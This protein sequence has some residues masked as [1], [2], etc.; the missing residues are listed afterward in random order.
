MRAALAA[1]ILLTPIAASAQQKAA[2]A[3]GPDL[4]A[5][6]AWITR[7][8]TEW[9]IPGVAVGIVKDGKVV[10]SKG[11]GYRN[12]EEK[13]P[14]TEKTI[15]A[16]GSNTKSF[17]V[18]L[19][20]KLVDQGKLDWE[21]PVRNYLPDFRLYDA[22]ATAEMTPRDLVSHSSG[23]PR[24]DLL[25]YGRSWGRKE[26]YQRLQYLEPTTS[27]RGR[28]QYQNLMFIT[29]GYLTEQLTGKSWEQ[30]LQDEIFNPLG[31]TR[32]NTSVTQTQKTDDFSYPYTTRDSQ[33]VRIPFRQL[34]AAGP[35]GS[36]NSSVEDMLKYIQMR[37][38]SGVAGGKQFY[39][40]AVNN[41][42]QTPVIVAPGFAGNEATG[43]IG[44]TT[45]G[46]GVAI[47][48]YRGHRMVIHGG[49]ID[50]FLSQMSWLPNERVG[51]IVLT[52]S[53]GANIA[54]IITYAIYD[55]M[56]GL[57]PVDWIG[58]QKEQMT[59]GVIAQDSVRKAREGERKM[60]TS[61][62][63]A[64]ADYAGTYE[65]PGYGQIIV[66]TNGNGLEFQ[67]DTHKAG[68][69]HFHYDV[70][71]IDDA[72]N[73]VPLNGRISFL[74]NAKGVVDRIAVPIEQA[75]PD[76]IFNRAGQ[77]GAKAGGQ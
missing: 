25:W 39:S 48:N 41:K 36:I 55:F 74:T 16:I 3:K 13:L 58:R 70:F 35:A 2:A 64:L 17:T 21:K 43:D 63:H 46:L 72:Q 30:Q 44:P 75:L 42:M 67:F 6:D 14:V 52:N 40:K 61:P 20:G 8:M 54:N 5:L 11:Y 49:G 37:I 9:K 50:G 68:L 15:M 26:I 47:S 27:F 1:A 77:A 57:E 23:L 31:M 65:H 28:F 7:A 33:V 76:R 38:D 22:Y 10:V 29:A 32:T 45:Y 62:G 19:M 4:K 56:L 53:T 18:V 66:T 73:I 69:K 60:G 24:H 12:V 34:D 59:R 71:E 51:A